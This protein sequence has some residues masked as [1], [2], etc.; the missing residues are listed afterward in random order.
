MAGAAL[1]A[2]PTPEK[3]EL[4]GVGKIFPST[5]WKKKEA[6]F[7]QPPL[8]YAVYD[9]K[10]SRRIPASGSPKDSSLSRLVQFFQVFF[11]SLEP[12]ETVLLLP[13]RGKNE[14]GGGSP[15]TH[16]L[17][18]IHMTPAFQTHRDEAVIQGG[19]HFVVGVGLTDQPRAVGSPF[20]VKFQY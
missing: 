19:G 18:Q 1:V 4:T 7:F 17:H 20:H 5:H 13:V 14:G 6:E 15:D 10:G 12:Y 8:R 11:R 9:A 16:L 2:V 3:P